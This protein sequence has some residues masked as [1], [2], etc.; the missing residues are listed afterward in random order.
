MKKNMMFLALMFFILSAASVN[1][2]VLIGD[3]D[4]PE[5][6]AILELRSDKLGLLLPRVALKFTDDKTTIES[7]VTGLTVYNTNTATDESGTKAVVPGV[8]IFDGNL[9]IRS[10]AGVAP[11]IITQPKA[12]SWSR[13]KETNGDPNGPAAADVADAIAVLSVTAAGPG[14]LT[15]QWYQKSAN[16]NAPDTKLSGA[17]ASTYAPV[18]TDW[19]MKSY[20]CVVKNGTD[21]VISAIADVAIG[22]GAKTNQGRWLRFMCHN[23]GADT[24]LDPFVYKSINDTTSRDIKGWLF[25]WGRNADGHQW[26]SSATVEG[27]YSNINL[28]FGVPNTATAYYGKF[29]TNASSETFFDWRTPQYDLLW[30]NSNYDGRQPCPSGWRLPTSGEWGSIYRGDSSFGVPDAATANTWTLT[31]GGCQL[32]PDG[33]TTTLFLPATG[34]RSVGGSIGAAAGAGE[35]TYWSSTSASNYAF[36]MTFN[37]GVVC[38]EES[39][40]RGTGYSARC[41]SETYD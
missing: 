2:Q 17:I 22:C 8:Y 28:F 18:V 36:V 31:S 26:R 14:T 27:P 32:K 33:T 6:T 5:T 12:F 34:G 15:Y 7:P 10:S 11:V 29:I 35:G 23:L 16:R 21:S 38:P 3:G 40:N 19:G 20:Y 1:A 30:R 24:G 37:K 13:L 25:Q 9:W 4:T 39:F 41:V